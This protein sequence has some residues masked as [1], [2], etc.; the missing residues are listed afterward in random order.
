M[1]LV[2]VDPVKK[3]QYGAVDIIEF[4]PKKLL[5]AATQLPSL[6]MV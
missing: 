5:R 6:S 4:F 1:S 2:T 3:L